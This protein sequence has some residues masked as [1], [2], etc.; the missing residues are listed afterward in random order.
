MAMKKLVPLRLATLLL[1]LLTI[2][3]LS[4]VVFTT[5][6]NISPADMSFDGADVVVSNCTVTVDG[7]HSFNSVLVTNGGV[8]THTFFPSG[9]TTLVFN[10]TN[11]PHILDAFFPAT[12]LNSNISGLVTVTDTNGLITY[13]NGV[14]YIQNNLPDGTTQI[15]ATTNSSMAGYAMVLV[16]YTWTYFE[17]AGLFLNVT[18]DLT[19]ASS[20]SINA[21]GIGYGPAFGI[22]RGFS[23]GGPIVEGS[24][25]SHAGRGGNC[26]SNATVSASYGTLYQ[27][28]TLGSGGGASY[29]GNGGSGGGEIQ[30]TAGGTV[31][32]DGLITANGNDATNSRAGGGSG[33]SIWITATNFSGLGSLTANGG[34]G[35]PIHG[36]GGGG[37][38][39][40]IQCGTNNFSG[41]LTAIGGTGWVAG[42]AG[43]VF[44]QTNDPVGLLILDN[45]SRKGTN[46][47]VTLSTSADVIVRNGAWL[48]PVSFSPR[49]L[50]IGTNGVLSPT[51]AQL[52]GLTINGNFIIQT[53]GSLTADLF[54]SAPATGTGPGNFGLSNSVY[55]GGG[56]GHGGYG[57]MGNAPNANGGI[58]Y[59]SQTVPATLGS[60]GG[61][62]GSAIGGYGGGALQLTVTGTVQVD[63]R[64]SANG[65]DGSVSGG[66]GG[67]GGGGSGGSIYIANC[68][69]LTGSGSIN[70]NGG[71][72]TPTFGG[73]GGGG[74]IAINAGNNTFTGTLSAAGGGGFAYG[75]AGTIYTQFGSTQQLTADNAG[76]LGTNTTIISQNN[77]ALI[78]RNGAKITSSQFL[79]FSSLLMSSNGWLTHLPNNALTLTINGNAVIQANCGFMG[80]FLG[81]AGG[82]GLGAGSSLGLSPY[83]PG[84]GGGY[85]GK[86]GAS[87]ASSGGS[88]SGNDTPANPSST[89]SGSGGG[90]YSP[91]IGGSGGGFLQFYVSGS[92]QQDGL[93]SANGG[94]GSGPGGGGG[95]GGGIYMNINSLT[96][97]GSITAN[98]GIGANNI[99]GGGGGGR[100][101]L[102]F[103]SNNFSGTF[104]ANGGAGYGTGGGGTIYF[105]TNNAP[106]GQVIVDNAG[107]T[108]A[109][110]TWSASSTTD[111]TLR[112]GGSCFISS[113]GTSFGNLT[114]GTNGLLLVGTNANSTTLNAINVIVQPGGSI[115]ADLNGYGP[116]SGINS[117]AGNF[118]PNSPYAGSGAGHGGYGGY[119]STNQ[120][121]A[122][123]AYDTASSPLYAGS[124][125]GGPSS[126]YPSVGG[127]GG[128]FLSLSLTGNLQVDGN[129]SANAGT[130]SGTG[131]GGG[132][133][134][135][136]K[137]SC[138]VLSGTGNISA[139]GGSGVSNIG[140]GG[141]GGMIYASFTSN[142]FSGTLTSYGGGGAN[143]GGAGTIYLQTN[144]F[145]SPSGNL[146]I[147]DNGGHR[148]AITPLVTAN[149]WAIRNGAMAWPISQNATITS[150]LITSNAWLVPSSSAAGQLLLN[151][152]GTATIQS[153]GS[154]YADAY[155][156]AQNLGTGRGGYSTTSPWFACSGGGYGGY[157]ATPSL[158]SFYSGQGSASYGSTTSPNVIGSGGGGYSTFS[159]GGSGGG[160]IKLVYWILKNDGSITANG[161]NGSGLGGGGGSGGSISLSYSFAAGPG[162]FTGSGTITANGGNGAGFGGGGGGG[163]IAYSFY[164]NSFTGKISAFGG[165]GYA[166]GGAGTI[167]TT[168][169]TATTGGNYG[170]LL[171]DN[172][173]NPGTNSSF[174]FNNMDVIV[175]NKA[176]GLL[177]A[178][179]SWTVHNIVIRTNGTLTGPVSTSLTTVNANNLTIDAGGI[180]SL[181]NTGNGPQT[182]IGFGY[183]TSSL[184]GGG[185]YGGFG[186]GNLS[187]FGRAYGSIQ[188][189][190]AAG[191]GGASY[192]SG[193]PYVYGGNGGGALQ[194]SVINSGVLTVNGRLSANGG[195]GNYN[196]GG[197]SG[198]S[199]NLISI[200]KLAGSGVIS[201]NGGASG[202]GNAGGGGGGRIAL[203]CTSNAF[204]GQLTASGG[205]GLFPGGAG[206]IYTRINNLRSLLVDNGGLAG[207]NTPLD[208]LNFAMPSPPFNLNISGAAQVVPVAP[209]PLVSNLTLAAGASIVAPSAQ[210][211]LVLVV[212]HNAN[213]AGNISLDNFGYAQANGPGAGTNISNKGSGGGYGGSGGNSASGALGG[214]TYGSAAQP[215]DFGS[216]GGKGANNGTGGSEGGGAVRIS[217]GGTLNI[218]GNLSANGDY[219]WQDDSG[220][221]AG[222][223][224]WI[225]ANTLTGLGTISAAGGNGDFWNGGGG[226]GGRI[227]IYSPTNLFAG[228]TNLAGG[229]GAANG[230]PGT[231]FLAA[232]PVDFLVTAQTPTGTVSNT[233]SSVDL[234]FTEAVDPASVSAATFTL[235]TPA[236][237]IP[238]A[239]LSAAT[240][241]WAPSAV[242]VS[243]PVQ[244]LPGNYSLQVATT[245]TNILGQPLAQTFTGNFTIAL[246][247]ISGTVN[248]TNGAPVAGVLVQPDGGLTGATTDVNGNYSVG[249]P[250]GWNGSLTPSLDPFVFAPG[251]LSFS[252]VTGSLTSQNFI[253]VPSFAP[254]LS[255]S[256]NGTGLSLG[257]RGIP[258]IT[259][260][261]W[262]STNL[263]DWAAYGGAIS[264]TNGAMQIA[265]P[266]DASPG[267]FFR[268]SAS[269]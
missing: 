12:L 55:C 129:L 30:I 10:V 112:N 119:P 122:G 179:G 34:A 203:I 113:G 237:V 66:N 84:S 20:G 185:G 75:G 160:Y 259:Y 245:L 142:R 46:T 206:T 207:T 29:A 205:N 61:N 247:T 145:T 41:S 213:L 71:N 5:S 223:S 65:G 192:N 168:T 109:D 70:A 262:S 105:K 3:Q 25:A 36:G 253:M 159:A 189:P 16:S 86:G 236:G 175:Q 93:I 229:L 68:A 123:S 143:Y 17:N 77:A 15:Y 181:D 39:I 128:G 63:G 126:G 108:G 227:A 19:V 80:D 217:V 57:A 91:S 131:G 98:G 48:T 252:N 173:N 52:L 224:I 208:A 221:G 251:A 23:S 188:L 114:V 7:A 97:S 27:P 81:R 228:I 127:R 255:P 118:Y 144:P 164:T 235:T 4:A 197:G 158:G 194:L 198:G 140:G 238:T 231:L 13:T 209:L 130:G 202:G 38:R 266:L 54:G 107:Q 233:V 11:E 155:G 161:G 146:L 199:L 219:G 110:T 44:T 83:Y 239:N 132:A 9:S 190:T 139:N 33:G 241:T 26:S 134:G 115:T 260:Q 250:P 59:G 268:I 162:L 79:T 87:I 82:Q 216:G 263:V 196:C 51:S 166:Y 125:G 265:F 182:G 78:I 195:S 117:G 120:T 180:L 138:G 111:L 267:V 73:G 74:R 60:G 254:D 214:V 210:S 50:T 43:T 62:N 94:N 103:N 64:I 124:G 212:S 264:G 242:R 174:D 88:N 225:S 204:T 24:G 157:G 149:N 165:G 183:Y 257:W 85:G 156:S 100:I 102:Y 176:I 136:V 22:G 186:G 153:G 6:T 95:A 45:G 150:L 169:N 90:I 232:T 171:L 37:G 258:G 137:I 104:S 141:G 240:L 1:F 42:G 152:N 121:S 151:V 133:G 69:L 135:T 67:G 200:N 244:N 261:V 234:F 269:N 58:T 53:G 21:N 32:I 56:G 201:A 222:G 220:G 211:Q 99:G 249:V 184:R 8:L 28:A 116:N 167:Y 89:Y 256:V 187:G 148:G 163:R 218:D 246:P 178:S 193:P 154:I 92:L 35:E 215:V 106:R 76:H 47:S 248:D 226:G 18:N 2:G 31:N 40:S 14:D 243:F 172:A 96:G 101:A 147:A 72:G 177:P 230:Q 170:I 191:S 49:N